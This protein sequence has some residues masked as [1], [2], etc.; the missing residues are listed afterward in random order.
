MK[1]SVKRKRKLSVKPEHCAKRDLFA[2]LT[3]AI[4]ALADARHGRR[5]LRTH[6]VQSTPTRTGTP[7]ER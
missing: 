6:S 2:E 3:E 4:E 5:T 1:T 7:N